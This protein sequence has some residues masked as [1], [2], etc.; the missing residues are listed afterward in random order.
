MAVAA[1]SAAIES[2]NI[3]LSQRGRQACIRREK[4]E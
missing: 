2:G 3:D 4:E 1:A